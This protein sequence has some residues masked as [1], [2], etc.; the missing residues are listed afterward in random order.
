MMRP[1]LHGRKLY[2]IAA[3]VTFAIPKCA[4]ISSAYS[5]YRCKISKFLARNIFCFNLHGDPPFEGITIPQNQATL[6]NYL[7]RRAAQQL[8]LAGARCGSPARPGEVG[9]VEPC[10]L[11]ARRSG[12]RL[13]AGLLYRRIGYRRRI[14]CGRWRR[15]HRHIDLGRQQHAHG[16]TLNGS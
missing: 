11:S 12:A 14:G 15:R 10:P 1:H 9:T 2:Y 4:A 6:I 5:S 3:T 16:H 8:R 13:G 7:R